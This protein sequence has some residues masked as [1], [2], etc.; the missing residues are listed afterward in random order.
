MTNK[1]PP[2]FPSF[3]GAGVVGRGMFPLFVIGS[4]QSNPAEQTGCIF[5]S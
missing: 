4:L 5:G 2:L 3:G 1:V